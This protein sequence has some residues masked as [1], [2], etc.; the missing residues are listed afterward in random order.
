[1]YRSV[2][3]E[4]ARLIPVQNV[5]THRLPHA[6]HRR[7]P[8]TYS[9]NASHTRELARGMLAVNKLTNVPGK[10]GMQVRPGEVR[11]ALRHQIAGSRLWF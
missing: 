9:E 4:F 3:R 7:A 5:S 2:F 10:V 1:M 11:R 6:V 8:K